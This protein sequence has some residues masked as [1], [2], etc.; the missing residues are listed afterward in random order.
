MMRLANGERAKSMVHPIFATHPIDVGA[1]ETL[2]QSGRVHIQPIER[3]IY[4]C[5]LD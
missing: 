4:G 2:A 1:H 5:H 3:R